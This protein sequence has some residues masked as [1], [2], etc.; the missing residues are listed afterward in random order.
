MLNL[1]S[2][3]KMLLKLELG[4]IFEN[5]KPPMGP[6]DT[7]NEKLVIVLVFGAV[8]WYISHCHTVINRFAGLCS[9]FYTGLFKGVFR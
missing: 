3:H 6:I 4:R 8:F 1:I 9:G 2:H 7:T 5:H